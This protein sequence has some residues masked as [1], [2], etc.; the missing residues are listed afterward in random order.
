MFQ[1]AEAELLTHVGALDDLNSWGCPYQ[2]ICARYITRDFVDSFGRGFDYRQDP[3]GSFNHAMYNIVNTI[4]K[5]LQKESENPSRSFIHYRLE[6]QRRLCLAAGRQLRFWRLRKAQKSWTNQE[7]HP[8][9]CGSGCGRRR[10]R[11]GITSS[12]FSVRIPRNCPSGRLTHATSL[13]EL[14]RSNMTQSAQAVALPRIGES[15][16]RAKPVQGGVAAAAYFCTG[17]APAF[18]HIV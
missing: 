8:Q 6:G 10:R 5:I 12:H 4:C 18:P 14:A 15:S 3:T 11:P 1:R 17:T 2:L 7:G 16:Y 9:P 13:L